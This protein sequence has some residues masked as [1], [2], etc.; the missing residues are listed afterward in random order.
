MN[1]QD[2]SKTCKLRFD[3]S[4]GYPEYPKD[5]ASR[6]PAVLAPADLYAV[7]AGCM[8]G[9]THPGFVRENNEDSFLVC[10]KA[11]G[12]N[13]LA[14]VADGVG[15]CRCGEVA[16]RLCLTELFRQWCRFTESDDVTDTGRAISFLTDAVRTANSRVF[17]AEEQDPR[18]RMCTTLAAVLFVGKSV[19]SI[20]AGDSR[21]YR[22]RNGEA[23]RLT[24]DHSLV[25]EM[26]A[27]GLITPEEAQYHPLAHVISRTVGG[28][29]TVQPE[30]G[31]FEHS[32]GDRYLLCSDGLT[33]IVNDE[34]IASV[35]WQTF[36]PADAVKQ[37]L[38][39]ALKRGGP[40]N[41]TIVSVFG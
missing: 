8:A 29:E 21:V 19:V 9:D 33:D 6:I 17:H 37:L 26:I 14:A 28:L 15:G 35:V 30:T 18:D 34:E 5:A 3:Y 16:S 40:D 11:D 10:A 20:H 38:E 7:P 39:L 13:S 2:P 32:P 24:R 1:R 25:G 22:I 31:V 23:E 4:G 36:E 41:V 27:D 12:H